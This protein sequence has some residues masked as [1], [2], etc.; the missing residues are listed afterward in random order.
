MSTKILEYILEGGRQ[1][2]INIEGIGGIGKT[3]LA[4]HLITR[5][6]RSYSQRFARVCWVRMASLDQ[7]EQMTERMMQQRIEQVLNSL[8]EQVDLHEAIC[9]PPE[10]KIIQIQKVLKA[11]PHILVID[12]LQSPADLAAL[13]STIQSLADPGWVILTCRG[14]SD[15]MLEL[16][17]F[18]I[19]PLNCNDTIRMFRYET[20]QLDKKI[21]TIQ[22]ASDDALMDI[23]D[24]T[25]GHP[26]AIKVLIG[27]M[28][29]VSPEMALHN[30]EQ[31]I[32]RSIN[33]MYRS[34]YDGAW[35]ALSDEARQVL[36]LFGSG[37][38]DEGIYES[39]LNIRVHPAVLTEALE[40]LYHH[41]LIMVDHLE[42]DRRYSIHQIT[43]NYIR[44]I[45][46]KDRVEFEV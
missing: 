3:A 17:A 33:Q 16:K 14:M 6:G 37:S 45:I 11:D 34:V 42:N 28:R 30:L 7:S 18:S 41:K 9:L 46:Q 36:R 44:M 2:I 24:V 32:G 43:R 27:Q 13:A 21:T 35:R 38:P 1:R 26:Q 10:Q 39:F 22:Q 15:A 29:L 20:D 12:N 25:Q 40:E 4:H 5:L 8:C 23:Y 31:G 19:E